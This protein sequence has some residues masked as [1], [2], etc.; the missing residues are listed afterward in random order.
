MKEVNLSDFFLV[1]DVKEEYLEHTNQ[2]ISLGF[3]LTHKPYGITSPDTQKTIFNFINRLLRSWPEGTWI[4]KQDF[5]WERMVSP[6][7]HRH[8]SDI[9]IENAKYYS[10]RHTLGHASFLYISY[11]PEPFR[12]YYLRDSTFVRLVKQAMNVKAG[13]SAQKDRHTFVTSAK[14]EIENGTNGFKGHI[15][16]RKEWQKLFYAYYS[17]DYNFDN[18]HVPEVLDL[19]NYQN[20]SEGYLQRENVLFGNVFLAS[21]PEESLPLWGQYKK[22]GE[23]GKENFTYTPNED[24]ENYSAFPING[25]L[26]FA[27][28]TTVTIQK[29]D[30]G[31]V[32]KAINKQMKLNSFG[33]G[34]ASELNPDTVNQEMKDSQEAHAQQLKHNI[35]NTPYPACSYGVSVTIPS[36]DKE[37]L[38]NKIEMTKSAFTQY[39]AKAE[40]N[41]GH[42]MA[43]YFASAPAHGHNG[44]DFI[45]SQSANALPFFNI[46]TYQKGNPSGIQYIDPSTGYPINFEPWY[47]PNLAGVRN[48]YTTGPTRG[49]KSVKVANESDYYFNVGV[50][51]VMIEKGRSYEW[52]AMVYDADYIDLNR[53]GE[54]G[55]N[56]F[57][58]DPKTLSE[59]QKSLIVSVLSRMYPNRDDKVIAG[60]T[61]VL[62]TYNKELILNGQTPHIESFFDYLKN[63]YDRV[64]SVYAKHMDIDLYES[65]VERFVF[66][67]NR[68]LFNNKKSININD[69]AFVIFE[70]KSLESSPLFSLAVEAILGLINRKM[71]YWDRAIRMMIRIDEALQPFEDERSSHLLKEF[72]TQVGKFNAGIDI[73]V[74]S[75]GLIKKLPAWDAVKANTQLRTF[76]YNKH[77]DGWAETEAELLGWSPYRLKLLKNLRSTDRFRELL[78]IAGEE[79][80]V[81]GLELSPIANFVFS[82]TAEV[83]KEIQ[84][85]K[86]ENPNKSMKELIFDHYYQNKK[87]KRA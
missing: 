42:N 43:N 29:A 59:L 64:A 71:E 82:T 32:I 15:L 8:Y 7:S 74:Q 22:A 30:S 53:D 80:L 69:R 37:S 5:F 63:K 36:H 24:L 27:H 12:N 76:T 1:R 38:S 49:G 50:H 77:L 39:T 62:E 79:E 18:D 28:C 3:R 13:T 4:Q 19:G 68:W 34:G 61:N 52:L 9:S 85:I 16:S 70:L 48:G 58:Y 66:G 72:Y 33:F 17:G 40:F 67:D 65:E 86:Y 26:P 25:G 45:L 84:K 75:V 83:R 2:E 81:V 20:T 54:I 14:Q 78:I 47:N 35:V 73:M 21:E 11:I 10:M 31:A 44:H 6:D 55:I 60:V 23:N 51:Q 87:L 56:L 57:G 46:N 41:R